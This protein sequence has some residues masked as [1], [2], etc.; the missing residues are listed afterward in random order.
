MSPFRPRLAALSLALALSLSACGGSAPPPPTFTPIFGSPPTTEPINAETCPKRGLEQWLQRATNL[1]A[2]FTDIVNKSLT[3][4]P[5][6]FT[7]ILNRLISVRSVALAAPYPPCAARHYELLNTVTDDTVRT[8]EAYSLG[9]ALDMPSF[10]AAINRQFDELRN[11]E[12]EL[13]TI[14]RSLP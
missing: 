6:Q 8:L 7:P 5:G 14:Y 4:P 1:T 11:L 2:E 3:T 10:I 13:N 12:N 9:S